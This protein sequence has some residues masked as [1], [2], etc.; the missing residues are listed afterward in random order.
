LFEGTHVD[1]DSGFDLSVYVSFYLELALVDVV[2]PEIDPFAVGRRDDEIAQ[3]PGEEGNDR[4]RNQVGA[5]Q[6]PVRNP[7]AQDGYNFGI[8]SH[9]GSE[10]DY[11]NKG[12]K[13]TEEI[14]EIRDEIEV[15]LE[16]DVI[17]G[18]IF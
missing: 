1:V 7:A 15:I 9:F 8:I 18:D 17:R 14:G 11:G 2:V 4:G 12:K 16:Y 13:R 10:V 6:P 5:H 3:E